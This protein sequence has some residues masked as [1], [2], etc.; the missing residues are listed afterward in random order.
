M[1][2]GFGNAEPINKEKVGVVLHEF[3]KGNL[4]SGPGKKHKAKNFKQALAI[5]LSEGRKAAR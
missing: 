4:H 2:S 3:K 5:A 1:I